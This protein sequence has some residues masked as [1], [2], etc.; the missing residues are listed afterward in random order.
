M[1]LSRHRKFVLPGVRA[2]VQRGFQPELALHALNPMRRVDVLDA[3]DLVAGRAA[4]PGD[5]GA[6]G[7]EELP[8]LFTTK[9]ISTWT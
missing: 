6:V 5:D 8:D 9:H 1:P 2:G 3:R 7:E 4:L